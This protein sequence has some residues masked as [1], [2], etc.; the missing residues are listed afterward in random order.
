MTKKNEQQWKNSEAKELLRKA[1]I[2]GDISLD[3]SMKQQDVYGLFST[4]PEFA[5]YAD[6]NAFLGRLHALQKQLNDEKNAASDAAALAHD[7]QI[8]PK[9]THNHRGELRWE[10]S[11]AERFLRLDIDDGNH[12]RMKP[13][14]LYK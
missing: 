10:G 13:Q 12:E 1:L 11:E 4:R 6:Y 14:D 8:F 7:R 2:N 5:N 3:G 9:A